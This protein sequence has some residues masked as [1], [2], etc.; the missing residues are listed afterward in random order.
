MTPS[1]QHQATS[2]K[3]ITLGNQEGDDEWGVRPVQRCKLPGT[4]VLNT[5]QVPEMIPNQ[6]M[7]NKIKWLQNK[8]NLVLQVQPTRPNNGITRDIKQDAHKQ[9]DSELLD[10]D[11]SSLKDTIKILRHQVAPRNQAATI[12]QTTPVQQ[13]NQVQNPNLYGPSYL[14]APSTTTTSGTQD[15]KLVNFPQDR[16]TLKGYLGATTGAL[17]RPR[18]RINNQPYVRKQLEGKG[19]SATKE[20]QQP[21]GFKTAVIIYNRCVM[22]AMTGVTPEETST[23]LTSMLSERNKGDR[24]TWEQKWTRGNINS[25]PK[26]LDDL[27]KDEGERAIASNRYQLTRSQ[28]TWRQQV[29]LDLRLI[30]DKQEQGVIFRQVIN[31]MRGSQDQQQF[32]APASKD[33]QQFETPVSKDQ[34]QFEAPVSQD[35]QQAEA[36]VS[37]DQPQF[38]APVS[39][40]QQQFEAPGSQDQPGAR[41]VQGHLQDCRI[42]SPTPII[43]TSPDKQTYKNELKE[44]ERTDHSNHAVQK[45]YLDLPEPWPDD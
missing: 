8:P 26:Y 28:G 7:K 31:W 32:E 11:R 30:K 38:E 23:D 6:M 45:V 15:T 34:Q 2:I 4:H 40:D 20:W 5:Q 25:L 1:Q 17:R 14:Q 16:E 42:M 36:P 37:Q 43:V 21:G 12:N 44:T 13:R 24:T 9:M 19:N 29:N 39:Q 3:S 35:Q 41:T 10:Q 18:T 33:Q 27:S 22:L